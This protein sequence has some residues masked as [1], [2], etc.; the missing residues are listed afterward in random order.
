MRKE[1]KKEEEERKSFFHE[2]ISV[3]GFRP[4]HLSGQHLMHILVNE[5]VVRYHQHGNVL[6]LH[7]L[8]KE[9]QQLTRGLAVEFARR[10]VCQDQSA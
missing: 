2:V 4:P 6:S 1:G 5:W 7:K 3:S 9:R 10:F 8:T